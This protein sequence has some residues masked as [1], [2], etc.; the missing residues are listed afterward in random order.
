MRLIISLLFLTSVSF[1]QTTIP[2][3]SMLGEIAQFPTGSNSYTTTIN[4]SDFTGMANGTDIQANGKWVF[5]KNKGGNCIRYVVANVVSSFPG[6][7]QLELSDPDGGGNP[8]LGF[9]AFVEE[10]EVLGE[11]H[12][13]SSGGEFTLQTLNQ[14]MDAYYTDLVS[15]SSGSDT[16]IIYQPNHPFREDEEPFLTNG[17]IAVYT[18]STTIWK[19]ASTAAPYENV[20]LAFL[21]EVIDTNYFVIKFSGKHKTVHALTPGKPYFLQDDQSWGTVPDEDVNDYMAL[22]WKDSILFLAEQRPFLVGANNTSNSGGGSSNINIDF[23]NG[24]FDY[25][26]SDTI[27]LVGLGGIFDRD[28]N[29]DGQGI[30]DFGL[31]NMDSVY[32]EVRDVV[33][34]FQGGADPLFFKIQSESNFAGINFDVGVADWGI[35]ATNS[36]GSLGFIDVTTGLDYILLNKTLKRVEFFDGKFGFND[37]QPSYALA[38]TSIAIWTGNGIDAIHSWVSLDS[39]LSESFNVEV[40]N[41]LNNINGS[42]IELGGDLIKGTTVNSVGHDFTLGLDN[43]GNYGKEVQIQIKDSTSLWLTNRRQNQ[44]LTLFGSS[45]VVDTNN[46]TLSST[47]S[48]TSSV[49]DSATQITIDNTSYSLRHVDSDEPDAKNQLAIHTSDNNKFGWYQDF[50]VTGLPSFFEIY[51]D[52]FV[53]A[54]F[55]EVRFRT[56]NVVDG[57]ASNGQVLSLVNELTGEVEFIDLSTGGVNL[58]NSDLSQTG[59]GQR[60]YSLGSNQSLQFDWNSGIAELQIGSS[61]YLG[62]YESANTNLTGMV[63]ND[64]GGRNGIFGYNY[65]SPSGTW[66]KYDANGIEAF[67]VPTYADK[68]TADASA[69]PTEYLYFTRAL[70]LNG[71]TIKVL[72]I[73]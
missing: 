23:I 3:Y 45:I 54:N 66:L 12:F 28:T 73:K 48:T 35:L 57:S 55:E 37:V 1:A 59:I 46:I 16:T 63:V 19:A 18:D 6:E 61:T 9:G 65:P 32:F 43:F 22:A 60:T 69:L 2:V 39:L 31:T 10:S 67:G 51:P 20:K 17:V 13:V 21:T 47:F 42:F 70:D 8:G 64:V 62:K 40:R 7:I 68:V 50:Q 34:D 27:F 58:A 38:D 71:D 26:S 52:S 14:C 11:G 29:I 36:T 25:N 15:G 33:F 4:V 53:V 30:Y 56:S 44:D 5:W 24:L 41:G 49:A 72:A